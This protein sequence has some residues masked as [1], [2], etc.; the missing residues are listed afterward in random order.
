MEL[1]ALSAELKANLA[2][3]KSLLNISRVKIMKLK[4]KC[5]NQKY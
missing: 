2:N 3:K 1:K 4:N 5:N